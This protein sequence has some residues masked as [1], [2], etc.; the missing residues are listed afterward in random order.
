MIRSKDLDVRV[1]IGCGKR[2]TLGWLNF[3]NS[4]ALKLAKS[5]IK[6]RLSKIMKLLNAAQ[7]ENIEWNIANK[8][9]FADAKKKIPLASCTAICIYTSHMVEHLS[10]KETKSFLGESLRVLKKNGV[11]RISVPDLKKAVEEYCYDSDADRFMRNM[12][13]SAP[14]INTIRE[15]IRILVAGYRHH[16]WMYDGASLSKIM[17]EAGFRDVTI[18]APGKTLIEMKDGLDLFERSDESVFVEGVK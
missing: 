10:Q 1:N 17:T 3:D 15:K 9:S 11:L 6:Y 2:P 13:V 5:P 7:I 4:P 14:P 16:Q 12:Y 8:V 18:Q